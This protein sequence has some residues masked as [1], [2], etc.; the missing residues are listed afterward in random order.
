MPL[1]PRNDWPPLYLYSGKNEEKKEEIFEILS[2][3]I[4]GIEKVRTDLMLSLDG[5]VRIHWVT[6]PPLRP[7]AEQQLDMALLIDLYRPDCHNDV[8]LMRTADPDQSDSP[9]LITSVFRFVHIYRY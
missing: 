9:R 6:W 3:Q 5:A 2:R 4:L 1:H 8:V 7:M